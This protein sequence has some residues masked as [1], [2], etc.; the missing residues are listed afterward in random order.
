[1][2]GC[3]DR[4]VPQCYSSYVFHQRNLAMQTAEAVRQVTGRAVEIQKSQQT[5]TGIKERQYK[6]GDLV[7]LFSPPN[8][9]DVLHS[10]PW[11]G[12]HKVVEV[13]SDLNTKINI[14]RENPY[15][16]MRG[17]RPT[18]EKWVHK[19]HLKPF[20]TIK[21]GRVMAVAKQ[22]CPSHLERVA[23]SREQLFF[24]YWRAIY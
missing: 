11:T 13:G 9:R 2:Y 19:H 4:A 24:K 12:P 7:L 15:K 20:L 10:Q 21:Q 16:E 23:S 3:D 8:K 6:V 14:R 18:L 5:K 1:M 22:T 17:R